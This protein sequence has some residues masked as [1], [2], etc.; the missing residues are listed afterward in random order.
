MAKNTRINLASNPTLTVEADIDGVPHPLIARFL[1]SARARLDR[2][3]RRAHER[4]QPCRRGGCAAIFLNLW[5]ASP[6]PDGAG[7]I[8]PPASGQAFAEP[9]MHRPPSEMLRSGTPSHGELP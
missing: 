4:R 8:L 1:L 6:T 5:V 2:K 7:G 9:P 3:N